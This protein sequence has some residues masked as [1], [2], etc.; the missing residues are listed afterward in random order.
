MRLEV[1]EAKRDPVALAS[2]EALR[3]NLGVSDVVEQHLLQPGTWAAAEGKAAAVGGFI[4]GVD[5]G[6]TEAMSA[7]AGYWPETG[8]LD[9]IGCFGD[10]PDVKARGLRDGCGGLYAKML[11]R[12][13]LVLTPGKVSDVRQ[14]IGEVWDRWGKPSAIVCDRWRD[15]ELRTVLSRAGWPKVPLVKRGM[16]YRDGGE[17]VRGFRAAF[18]RGL[19][20]PQRN[21][22]LSAGMASARTI[23]DPAGNSK[24]AKGAQG[25]RHSRSRDDAAAAAVLA[26]ALGWRK[27]LQRQPDTVLR[28]AIVG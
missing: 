1:A 7:V 14:L 4:L 9:A 5:L 23:S 3:L 15:A 25:G 8:R 18:L 22:L 12:D 11:S 24:L 27:A 26:V 6:T 17:D 2:F 20:T 28:T 16:G 21:L 10:D 13:E 19:V